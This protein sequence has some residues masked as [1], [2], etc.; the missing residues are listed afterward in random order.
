MCPSPRLAVAGLWTGNR[1]ARWLAVA[2]AGLNATDQMFFI[3]ANL[4]W[5]LLI[6]AADVVAVWGLCAHRSREDLSSA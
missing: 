6:I 1:R 5:S 4:F 2:A 3:P